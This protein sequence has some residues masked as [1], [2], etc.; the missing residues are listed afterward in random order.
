VVLL[1]QCRMNRTPNSVLMKMMGVDSFATTGVVN[2]NSLST[3]GQGLK[4]IFNPQ[5]QVPRL[6]DSEASLPRQKRNTSSGTLF[7]AIN[8]GGDGPEPEPET[9]AC[10]SIPN[11]ANTANIF[12]ISAQKYLDYYNGG[13]WTINLSSSTF[14][15]TEGYYLGGAPCGQE[16]STCRF[17]FVNWN[18]SGQSEIAS[19]GSSPF[20]FF[21]IPCGGS[22]LIT[23]TFPDWTLE[24]SVENH[25]YSNASGF[26][27]TVSFNRRLRK[28]VNG[29]Q[30]THYVYFEL[31][32]SSGTTSFTSLSNPSP[33]FGNQYPVQSSIEIDGFSIEGQICSVA[34]SPT[35]GA[36]LDDP[37]NIGFSRSGAT[38]NLDLSF[39]PS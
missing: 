16:G 5:V 29:N 17:A 10:N 15:S 31:V 8:G 33:C 28:V 9:P 20:T 19:G 3:V 37:N 2:N 35:G 24:R 27:S 22:Q 4:K 25:F 6:F 30:N 7:G 21:S 32:A 13:T 39:S 14:E 18:G 26:T 34:F 23:R 36:P 1:A 12:V 11:N 38:F